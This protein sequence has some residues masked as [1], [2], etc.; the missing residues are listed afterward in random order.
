[1]QEKTHGRKKL[2]G[3]DEV[4][5]VSIRLRWRE[6]DFREISIKNENRQFDTFYQ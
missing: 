1:M 2:Q 5:I 3:V 6:K 4:T